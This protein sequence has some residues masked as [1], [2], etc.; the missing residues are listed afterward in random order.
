MRTLAAVVSLAAL[1]AACG[2]PTDDRAAP[3]PAAT[4]DASAA[5]DGPASPP[6]PPAPPPVKGEQGG[7]AD[8][9]QVVSADH[10][11][12][13]GRLDQAWRLGRAE[14]EDKGFAEQVEALGPLVD[15]NA[16]QQGRLQPPPGT[17]RCR[18][19][20]LG[21]NSPG[22]PGYLEYPFFRCTIELTPGGDLILTKITGSQRTRGLLYP[23]TDRRLIYV[24]AAA[25]SAQETSYPDYG[26]DPLRDQVGVFERIGAARWRLAI[27]WPKVDSKL[28][29]LEL[30]R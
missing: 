3:P 15:P 22:G 5:A 7:T 18:T 19:I 10:A 29:I 12:N 23:D 24:G 8:W 9:R 14:A 27:P 30:V 13:L 11:A 2:D 1:L 16:G 17:Y 20:K 6:A 26:D 28:E 25:W 4:D 21:T